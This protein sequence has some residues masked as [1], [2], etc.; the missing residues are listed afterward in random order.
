MLNNCKDKNNEFLLYCCCLTNQIIKW[1]FQ[2]VDAQFCSHF[3]KCVKLAVNSELGVRYSNYFIIVNPNRDLLTAYWLLKYFKKLTLSWIHRLNFD[4]RKRELTTCGDW[5]Y[6]WGWLYRTCSEI[7]CLWS[8]C[9][10]RE[11]NEHYWSNR[12]IYKIVSYLQYASCHSVC[13]YPLS[14]LR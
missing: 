10:C 9:Q 4:G 7:A 1:P 13:V 12:P 14:V 6:H 3:G 2:I 5:K 11:E 8:T